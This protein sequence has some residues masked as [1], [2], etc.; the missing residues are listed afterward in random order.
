MTGIH[1]KDPLRLHVTL[2]YKD[3]NQ[4]LQGVLVANHGYVRGKDD[5]GFVHARHAGEKADSAKGQQG[6]WTVWPPEIEPEA[7]RNPSLVS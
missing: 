1:Q 7:A 2:C 3:E 6:K 5:I 4:I